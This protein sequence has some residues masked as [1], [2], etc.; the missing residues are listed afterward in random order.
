MNKFEKKY[1][2]IRKILL[3]TLEQILIHR[4]IDSISITDICSYSGIARS[5][6]YNH[7]LNISELYDDLLKDKF[8]LFI[9]NITSK[10]KTEFEKTVIFLE[11]LK[12]NSHIIKIFL[13][14][15]SKEH[16][17]KFFNLF[18]DYIL[19]NDFTIDND[20]MLLSS[21]YCGGYLSV[22]ID[23]YNSNFLASTNYIANIIIDLKHK[24]TP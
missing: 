10:S 8:N 3:D 16:I 13:L 2:N 6:F 23:W 17:S 12:S 14:N 4:N 9:K 1:D 18:K 20:D 7:Y 5:T 22:L 21:F 11:Y 15:S 19:A 24:I